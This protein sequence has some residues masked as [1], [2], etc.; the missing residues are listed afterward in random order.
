MKQKFGHDELASD[1]AN[2]LRNERRM[3]WCDIQLGPSG[4]VR[5]DVFAVNRSYS[6]PCPVSYECK[7]SI[8]D[9]RSDV[10]SGKWQN[11]LSFSS[12]VYFACE[13][14]LIGKA[15]VPPHC[16][17]IVRHDNTWRAAKKAVLNPVVV[18]EE[19]WLKLLIDGI[20]REG[21]K[22]RARCWSESMALDGVS[23]KFGALVAKAIRDR[24][25]VEFETEQSNRHAKRI[26]EN[27]HEESKRIRGEAA[28][29][30]GPM[31]AEICDVLGIPATTSPHGLKTAMVRLRDEQKNHPAVKA[32]RDF[33]NDVQKSLNWHGY[34]EPKAEDSEESAA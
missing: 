25:A 3:T 22:Y 15:D 26:I 11:Y 6:N 17:L 27:A 23:K 24:L 14:G 10:T 12:G 5:P 29:A 8:S 13:S 21:P 19:V 30:V 20:E 31:R 33:T 1:L 4:S 9:F 18:P 34:K 7:V 32:L 16:G 2:H 28:D